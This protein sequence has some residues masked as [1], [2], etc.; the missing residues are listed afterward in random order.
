MGLN[1][2]RIVEEDQQHYLISHSR[3]KL[4][5]SSLICIHTQQ[6]STM[7][8]AGRTQSPQNKMVTSLYLRSSFERLTFT[9]AHIHTLVRC[10]C[11]SQ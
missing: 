1:L 5:V 11:L 9:Q 10:W 3:E 2:C 6:K 7:V 4:F 8:E